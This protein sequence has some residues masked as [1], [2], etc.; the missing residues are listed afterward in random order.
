VALVLAFAL[1]FILIWG[2]KLSLGIQLLQIDALRP[3]RD[4]LDYAQVP[5]HLDDFSRGIIDTRQLFF[6]FT[7]TALTL[8]LTILGVEA[9]LL[10]N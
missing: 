9:R 1:L 3:V 5:Q 7:G 2:T 8:I 4:A 10:H 6:Y